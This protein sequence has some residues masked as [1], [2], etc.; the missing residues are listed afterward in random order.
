MVA[1]RNFWK[2]S[3]K[4]GCGETLDTPGRSNQTVRSIKGEY[5]DM[6]FI[7]FTCFPAANCLHSAGNDANCENFKILVRWSDLRPKTC[8]ALSGLF[9]AIRIS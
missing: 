7:F 6:G 5:G 4:R 2:T 1:I 8:Y 3:F 9:A